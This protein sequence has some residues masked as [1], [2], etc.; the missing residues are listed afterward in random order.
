MMRK[1]ISKL[2]LTSNSK[3]VNLSMKKVLDNLPGSWYNILK[4]ERVSNTP[5]LDDLINQLPHD[6]RKTRAN[7]ATLNCQSL[8]SLTTAMKT[9]WDEHFPTVNEPLIAG[10]AIRDSITSLP[11]N[12]IDVFIDLRGMTREEGDDLIHLFFYLLQKQLRAEDPENAFGQVIDMSNPDYDE[13]FENIGKEKPL[14]FQITTKAGD[15]PHPI[16]AD[17][18]VNIYHTVQ[19]IGLWPDGEKPLDLLSGFPYNLVKGAMTLDGK[20]FIHKE[21]EQGFLTN[22]IKVY[23]ERG[24]EKVDTW[25]ERNYGTLEHFQ[26]EDQFTTLVDKAKKALK[27]KQKENPCSEIVLPSKNFT[28]PDYRPRWIQANNVE[29]RN[30]VPRR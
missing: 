17:Q 18:R 26:I 21:M 11:F 16:H 8:S 1:L 20:V 22:T 7:P 9:V 27:L 5:S 23:S 29:I 15:R 3:K 14:I 19:I 4:D 6:Y 13:G 2:K 28:F 12:D 30:P 10:G 25:K 24:Q